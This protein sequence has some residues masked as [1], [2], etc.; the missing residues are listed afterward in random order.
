MANQ[1]AKK[2]EQAI[3][4]RVKFMTYFMY[5]L[6]GLFLILNMFFAIGESVSFWHLVWCTLISVLSFFCIKQTIKCWEL[7]L[8]A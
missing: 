4:G 6:F 8:P 5:P 7:Q 2:N 1:S 3:K